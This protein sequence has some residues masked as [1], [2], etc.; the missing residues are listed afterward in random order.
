[1]VLTK[2]VDRALTALSGNLPDGARRPHFIVFRDVPVV[3]GR[4][5]KVANTSIKWAL[6]RFLPNADGFLKVASRD[7]SWVQETDGATSMVGTEEAAQLTDRF[8]FTFVRNPFSRLASYY[9]DK[10][11]GPSDLPTAASR[12]GVRKGMEFAPFMERVAIMADENVDVHLL[13]QASILTHDGRLVPA[14]VGRHERIS[15]DWARLR[16]RMARFGAPDPGA[17]PR[18]N[19]RAPEGRDLAALFADPGVARL[20]R[21]RYAADFEL[22]YPEAEPCSGASPKRVRRSSARDSEGASPR[23]GPRRPT[24]R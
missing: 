23:G 19:Q 4:V 13:P 17:L 16:R 9:H 1:M 6:S 21:E 12:D 15:E 10:V 22:F 14:F 5:P 24:P 18:R 20:V 8:V 11:V 3:Y 2:L 7:I